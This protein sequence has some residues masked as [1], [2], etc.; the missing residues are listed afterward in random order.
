MG[1]TSV[2]YIA[3][4]RAF[5]YFNDRLFGGR[6]PDLL[7]TLTRKRG[8]WAY[9]RPLGFAKRNGKPKP[10]LEPGESNA[11]IAELAVNP[12]AMVGS[13]DLEVLEAIGHEMC[14]H[15]QFTDPDCKPSRRGYHNKEFSR[16]MFDVGLVCS[17]TGKPGGKKTGQRMSDY[18]LE[19]GP[20]WVA[21]HELLESGWKMNWEA[22]IVAAQRVQVEPGAP[23][24]QETVRDPKLKIKYRCTQP[25]CTVKAWGRP[26]LPLACG[27]HFTLMTPEGFMTVGDKGVSE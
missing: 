8:A 5:A 23:G 14:H 4:E 3:L 1:I 11:D 24:E 21:A 16:L 22:A 6:L 27:I 2:E 18:P 12:V 15:K 20:F 17:N 19:G 13:D 10:H 26:D 25:G 7:F 9:Y